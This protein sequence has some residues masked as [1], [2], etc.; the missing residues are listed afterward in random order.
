MRL[1]RGKRGIRLICSHPRVPKKG[2]LIVRAYHLLKKECPFLSGVI[3]RLTKRIPIG[4]GLGGGSSNAAAFLVGMN[5]LYRLGLTRK[6]LFRL[7]K[8]LGA[9][10]PFFLAGVRHTIGRARGDR[11]HS[12]PFRRRLWFL[13]LCDR[14]GLSTRKVYQGLN[15]TRSR[16]SLT[17]V[18]HDVRLASAFLERGDLGR[19]ARFLVN[20]LAASAERLRPSLRK[21]RES[22]SGLQLGSCQMSGSGPTLFFIFP[23]RRQALQAHQKLRKSGFS[24]PIFV[25]HSF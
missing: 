18:T 2:N 24:Q 11:I 22:L 25:C 15:S 19:A 6:R 4:A 17:R 9:D 20:D 16:P 3:V 5:R 10:V 1:R 12:I 21:T 7:G 14:R 13:L 8:K 23:S